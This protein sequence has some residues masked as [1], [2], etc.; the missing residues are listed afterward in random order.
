M[1]QTEKNTLFILVFNEKI[2]ISRI[3]KTEHY[4]NLI[5]HENKVKVNRDSKHGHRAH[6]NDFKNAAQKQQALKS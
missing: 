5:D 4:I 6:C 1:S 3:N 2:F